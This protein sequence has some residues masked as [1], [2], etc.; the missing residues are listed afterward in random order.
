MYGFNRIQRLHGL[1]QYPTTIW[2]AIVVALIVVVLAMVSSPP[3]LPTGSISSRLRLFGATDST[4]LQTDATTSLSTKRKD[5]SGL[6]L[7]QSHPGKPHTLS[8]TAHQSGTKRNNNNKKNKRNNNKAC[9]TPELIGQWRYMKNRRF[10]NRHCCDRHLQYPW[11][12]E[13]CGHQTFSGFTM[14]NFTMQDIEQG[15]HSHLAFMQGEGCGKRCRDNFQDHY[16]W[17]SPNLPQWNPLEFC[18]LLGPTRRVIMIG[19]STMAQASSTLINAVHGWC[20]TQLAF[21]VSDSLIHEKYGSHNRGWHWLTI[22]RNESLVRDGDIVVLTVGAHIPGR[23]NLYNVSEVVLE[24]I[25]RMKDERPSVTIVYK[26][27]QPGGCTKEIANLTQSP[28]EVGANFVFEDTVTYNH[29]LLYEYDKS[30]LRRLQQRNIPFLD[31]RMLFSRSDAHPSSKE[32]T[33]PIDCLHF[34]APGPL[35]M[36]AILFLHLLRTDFAVSRCLALVDDYANRKGSP[37]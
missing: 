13:F 27:Q 1:N 20:Q 33:N 12:H 3:I 28:L 11:E 16:V 17:E 7:I 8:L 10:T 29:P 25:S 36:F 9:V 24:Q 18:Q 30:V 5:K 26:T 32:R 4:M 31:M 22:A 21:Y 35:D 14:V 23:Y 19:D 2:V 37:S 6:V 34:C 15:P